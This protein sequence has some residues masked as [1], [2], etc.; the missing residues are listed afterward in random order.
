MN[1]GKKIALVLAATTAMDMP[2][3]SQNQ[4]VQGHASGTV[5]EISNNGHLLLENGQQLELWGLELSDAETA[6]M[7][8]E[9][10]QISCAILEET[11]TGYV[12]DCGLSPQNSGVLRSTHRLDLF[13]WLGEYG[14]YT[15]ACDGY[16]PPNGMI[17]HANNY[18][19]W[20]AD[21]GTPNRTLKIQLD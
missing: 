5:S 12:T 4:R 1:L 14:A 9:G 16:E 21:D 18:S 2:A 6:S 17:E 20:C 15:Y 10:R 7:L 13:T 19:Y 8:L 3:F 11:P